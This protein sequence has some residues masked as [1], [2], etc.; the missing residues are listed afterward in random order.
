MTLEILRDELVFQRW[1]RLEG[2][3]RKVSGEIKKSGLQKAGAG[4]IDYYI[5]AVLE[6]YTF[7]EVSECNAAPYLAAG[8]LTERSNKELPFTMDDRADFDDFIDNV[9]AAIECAGF[10]ILNEKEDSKSYSYFVDFKPTGVAGELSEKVIQI[11]F[12]VGVRALQADNVLT[13]M[14]FGTYLLDRDRGKRLPARLTY[15]TFQLAGKRYFNPFDL[16]DG[17]EELCAALA[18]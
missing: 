17:V 11:R 14:T 18:R 13:S 8:V 1:T 15:K 2:T 9:C 5:D 4:T 3:M 6:C 7:E 10:E 12:W 16:V